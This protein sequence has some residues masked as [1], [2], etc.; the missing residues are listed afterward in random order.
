VQQSDITLVELSQLRRQLLAPNRDRL[1]ALLCRSF[2][3]LHCCKS[4]LRFT[5]AFESAF[6]NLVYDLE[7]SDSCAWLIR[8][9][10]TEKSFTLGRNRCCHFGS[11]AVLRG[12]LRS[13]GLAE[14]RERG[15]CAMLKCAACFQFWNF[16]ILITDGLSS[17]IGVSSR[18]I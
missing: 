12:Y 14:R 13:K 10:L 7:S 4:F 3:C 5:M 9:L 15:H 18:T 16:V 17:R 6:R 11:S 2:I 1:P 8:S